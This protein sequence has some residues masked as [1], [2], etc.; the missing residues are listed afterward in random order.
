MSSQ[1]K[2]DQ[3]IVATAD[4][5]ESRWSA[6]QKV[7]LNLAKELNRLSGLVDGEARNQLRC[8]SDWFSDECELEEAIR[9]PDILGIVLPIIRNQGAAEISASSISQI[10]QRSLNLTNIDPS[11]TRRLWRNIRYPIAVLIFVGVLWLCFTI[12]LAPALREALFEYQGENMAILAQYLVGHRP[13]LHVASWFLVPALMLAVPILLFA[14]RSRRMRAPNTSWIDSRLMS[15]RCAVGKWAWHVSL[16]LQSGLDSIEAAK[17]AAGV[18][19]S[20][21]VKARMKSWLQSVNADPSSTRSRAGAFAKSPFKLVNGAIA[22]EDPEKKAS[23]LQQAAKYY[24]DRDR[25]I[26]DWWFRILAW[27]ILWNIFVA[28]VI[29]FL[30]FYGTLLSLINALTSW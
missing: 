20:R 2:T 12:G 22:V 25:V 14:S 29:V 8:W 30:T 15:T 5:L 13:Q 11:V 4:D 18:S 19:R 9:R 10:A 27:L 16:L 28:G 23:F 17:I 6:V 1:F 7:R 3:P 21:W 24:L 26:G